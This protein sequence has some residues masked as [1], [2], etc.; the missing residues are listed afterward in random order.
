MFAGIEYV[1]MVFFVLKRASVHK[2][3]FKQKCL[4][5]SIQILT[6]LFLIPGMASS[7]TPLSMI[8]RW[9][10][11]LHSGSLLEVVVFTFSDE[12]FCGVVGYM[13]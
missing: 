10:F 3:G 7:G 9:S 8:L 4:W 11:C 6:L 1:H 12:E 2:A 13:H 5:S